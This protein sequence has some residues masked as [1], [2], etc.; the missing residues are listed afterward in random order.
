[1]IFGFL[2]PLLVLLLIVIG[3]IALVRRFTSGRAR[4]GAGEAD[5]IPYGLLALTVIAG[6]FALAQLGRAA[7]PGDSFVFDARQQVAT[8]LATLVVAVPLAVYFWQRQARR[9]DTR[10]AAPGWTLYLTVIHAV[11]LTATV[12]SAFQL[13]EWLLGAASLPT[14]T[15]VVVYGGIVVAHELATRSTPPRSDAADLPRVVG[16]AAGLIP[17][18]IG[19]GGL[20]YWV[21][22]RLYATFAPTAGGTDA[23]TSLALVLVGAP[24]WV[25]YWLR[26]WRDEASAPRNAWTFLAAVAG[27]SG[28]IGS[29]VA[30]F[31]SILL[32]VLTASGPAGTHFDDL[33]VELTVLTMGAL[34]WWHHR[35]RLGGERT[36]PV[37]AYEHA[38]AAL[39]LVGAIGFATALSA[40]AFGGDL[41]VGASI[42]DII[43]LAVGLISSL[44]V[45]GWFW[46][47]A[48]REPREMEAV[49]WP[50][51]AYLLG[52]GII[53]GLVA[54]GAL[55]WTLFVLFRRLLGVSGTAD[56]LV[57][58]ASLFVFAGAAAWHLLQ[59]YFQDRSLVEAEEVITPYEVTLICSH[60][61]MIATLFPKEARLR[62][63]YRGDQ[64]APIDDENAAAIVEAVGHRSSLVWV[65]E[66]GFRVAPAR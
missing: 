12:I 21:L 13:L 47:R 27:L 59:T 55:I 52:M 19:L 14:F 37:R 16:S 4:G 34:V 39:G 44:A 61:G 48:G 36:D 7:F 31:I 20:V 50:R 35:G 17:L 24:V 9:R 1:M 5:L 45:W 2:L 46:W 15:D 60:P 40:T 62:V 33:P 18:V 54:A 11:F 53:T 6:G 3:G 51:R 64:I 65:D 42:D 22:E 8:S 23:R 58:Q 66:D 56:S 25:F 57:V 41:L 28:A 10:P 32:F 49:A 43:T 29:V 26:P 63:V 38:M 30:I